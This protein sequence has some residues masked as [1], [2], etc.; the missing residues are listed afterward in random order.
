MGQLNSTSD[1]IPIVGVKFKKYVKKG[2]AFKGPSYS[3]ALCFFEQRRSS[4]D[5]GETI[6]F[7]D[8][9]D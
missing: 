8:L 1:R 9:L 3:K 7:T 2:E 4:L 6:E 5:F